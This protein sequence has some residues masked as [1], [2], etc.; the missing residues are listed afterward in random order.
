M[1]EY[2]LQSMYEITLVGIFYFFRG[3]VQREA[4]I[5]YRLF[6]C[7]FDRLPRIVFRTKT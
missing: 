4:I 7:Y 2:I 1:E 6:L 3:I 5:M